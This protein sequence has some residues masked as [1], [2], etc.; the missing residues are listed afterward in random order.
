MAHQLRPVL[1]IVKL[2]W[3]YRSPPDASDWY[4]KFAER[5][6]VHY[7]VQPL[8]AVGHVFDLVQQLPAMLALL[9]LPT[10]LIYSKDDGAFPIEHGSLAY[11]S[12]PSEDK[13]LVVIEGSGHTLTRDAQSERVFNTVGNFVRKVTKS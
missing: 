1:P 6:N 2:F 4:D 9:Q 10:L 5:L 8:H 3:R 7:P 12:I 11:D 13:E